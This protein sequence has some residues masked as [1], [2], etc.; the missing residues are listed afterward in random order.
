MRWWIGPEIFWLLMYAMAIWISRLNVQE[1]FRLDSWIEDSWFWIPA[2]SLIQFGLW[3][4]PGTQGPYLWLRL[5][6]ASLIGGHFVLE[7]ILS[8]YS[9][10][11][12]GIGMGYLAGMML[13]LVFL[14]I[15]T[16]LVWIFKK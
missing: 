8:A 13:L 15:G 16:L 2:F 9:R 12:P 14:F 3:W 6:V 5:W 11:G 4:F 1:A 10:Q 7:K